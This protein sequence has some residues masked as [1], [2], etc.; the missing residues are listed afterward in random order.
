MTVI[1]GYAR[2]SAG[3]TVFREHLFRT[4]RGRGGSGFKAIRR[5]QAGI[6]V[7]RFFQL[8]FNKAL[9]QRD[10]LLASRWR[11]LGLKLGLAK[12]QPFE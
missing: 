2:F 3:G 5:D 12:K 8:F 7:R 9:R 1:G 10:G 11:K 4:R 6:C